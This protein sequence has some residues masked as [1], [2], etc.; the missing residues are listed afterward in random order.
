[1][2]D[3]RI[4][5]LY[6]SD[7]LC[8]LFNVDRET[9]LDQLNNHIYDVDHPEDVARIGEAAINFAMNDK[10]YNVL[11]RSRYKDGYKIIHARGK[12]IYTADGERLAIIWYA[13][14]GLY[15]DDKA[16]L[17]DQAL[18]NVAREV[19]KQQGNNYDSVTGL[20][21]TNY[22]F[23]LAD[24]AHD[25]IVES[26]R[27]PVLLYFDF[28]DMRNYNIK[29][30]F[31]EGDRLLAGLSGIL[32]SYFSNINCCRFG[33]DRFVVLTPNENIEKILKEIFE[34]VKGLNEG[35]SL[36]LR[37]GIYEYPSGESSFAV[38][39]DRAKMAC[40]M[41]KDIFASSFNYYDE[42]ML[43]AVRIREYILENLDT[44][45]RER[46]IQVYYQPIVRSANGRV[47]DEEALARWVDP[48]MGFMSPADFIPVLE[49]TKQIYKLD[50]C[51]LD[52]VIER[53]SVFE[54]RGIHIVPCSVN[55]SRS[56]FEMC[57]IVEEIRK[58]VD[59]AGISHDKFTIEITESAIATDMAYM[60][61]QIE[62][63]DRMGF[64]VWMD[65]Y[66]SG[67]SSPEMLQSIPVSTI[68]LDMQFMRQFD[69]TKK[70]R[71]IISELIN[72]ALN[73]G[74]DTVVE[75][76][77]T[78]EQ[79]EFLREVGATKLQG[80]YFCKPISFDAVLNRYETGKQI[81]FENPEEC[82]YYEAIG[83]VNLYD[84]SLNTG[85]GLEE[86]VYYNS[87]PMAIFEADDDSAWSIRLNKA[88]KSVLKK[89][90]K[91]KEI[92]DGK[93]MVFKDDEISR[94]FKKSLIR[95]G[96]SGVQAIEDK[97]SPDGKAIHTLFR[98]LAVNPVTG[99]KAI[100][101]IMLEIR[102]ENKDFNTLTY[103]SIAL[104]LSSDYLS[105]YYV[106]TETEKFVEYRTDPITNELVVE[107]NGT[108]FFENSRIDAYN[109]LHKDDR[110]GFINTFS[111]EI[112]LDYIE[113]YGSFTYTYRLLIDNSYVYV[114][115][116]AMDIGK[117]GKHIIIGVN[118]V[119]AQMREREALERLK[120]EKKA[121]SRISAL[122][123]DYIAFYMV[124]PVTNDYN[125]YDAN[126]DFASLNV[127]KSGKSFFRDSV[128]EAQKAIYS[129]DLEMFK[130]SFT[131]ENILNSI[132]KDGMY[133]ITYRLMIG[134]T[135]KYVRLKAA[136]VFENGR[137]VLL[138]GVNDVDA[139]V[140]QDQ[141][142]AYN[143]AVAR[144]RVNLDSLTGVKNKNAYNESEK[145]LDEQ[146]KEQKNLDFAIGVFDI[147]N[148]KDVNDR[149]GHCAGDQMIKDG[150]KIICD[151]FSHSPVFRVGGDE[152]AVIAN[153]SDYENIDSLMEKFY[154]IN[155]KSQK[156]GKIVV[157]GGVAKFDGDKYAEDVF[158]RAD[159]AMY[160]NKSKLKGKD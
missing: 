49:D 72:M 156:E 74:L 75:G 143:L 125:Q 117:N 149:L 14:E 145:A 73:L 135:Q 2:I 63:L 24:S 84:I 28:N 95:C 113:K 55:V 104:A 50:L 76:V 93:Y 121:F 87:L 20:P 59:R 94:S 107:R 130:E 48:T 124:D 90:F 42:T 57:D 40:D 36:T 4:K 147:N 82:G 18:E 155:V 30:G 100:A 65:D 53:I 43:K 157:A 51:V 1:M 7:G 8:D 137:N 150:C 160:E 13:D 86:G 98:R 54:E 41:N 153:G 19:G 122:S 35:K 133:T 99:R 89:S 105:L 120:E 112:V 69:K 11:Y 85:E 23:S 88:C 134:G 25:K 110:E 21:E 47:C 83:R 123:G 146:I 108:D 78:A 159:K 3:G 80:Y 16:S 46:W 126:S 118:N 68:K 33:S 101:V 92:D 79:V 138:F 103:G 62:L 27:K 15:K 158:K 77:E 39:C 10:E 116:K 119:D 81:G 64:K 67:Y 140:R 102:D 109:L 127:S 142:Y 29:Y 71:I 9:A 45:I 91:A 151:I 22:F 37:V 60:N 141:E 31:N 12:H 144:N 132:Q 26:G 139:R 17:F 61:S 128:K 114:N 70:S 44:A 32:V 34:K 148:L 96:Q 5:A 52:Q 106:N 129:E 97:R 38:A 152:F 111:K 136:S 154:E 56:D 115:M 66:G 6:V 131:K 58:R